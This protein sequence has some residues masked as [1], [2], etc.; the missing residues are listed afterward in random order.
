M[1]VAGL[2][3]PVRVWAQRFTFLGLLAAAFGLML[4]GKAETAALQQA[5]ILIVDG[6]APILSVL[7]RPVEAGQNGFRSAK[8]FFIVHAENERLRQELSLI[9][10]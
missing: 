2:A 9:H 3:V 10:I 7:S 8:S 4:L 6:V 5:R 1:S